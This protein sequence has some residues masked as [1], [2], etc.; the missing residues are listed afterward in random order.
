M[1]TN[2]FLYFERAINQE[3]CEYISGSEYARSQSLDQ[4]DIE[5]SIDDQVTWFKKDKVRFGYLIFY[6]KD[7][8]EVIKEATLAAFI[9]LWLSRLL[10]P[11]R[12]HV[13]RPE[14]FVMV[15]KMAQGNKI[16]LAPAV[17]GFVYQKLGEIC[18]TEEVPITANA[19]F[20][21]HLLV[22]WLGEHFLALYYH[23]SNLNNATFFQGGKQVKIK[24][25]RLTS[26]E[27]DEKNFKRTCRYKGL[28]PESSP[29]IEYTTF[30]TDLTDQ[31]A[32]PSIVNEPSTRGSDTQTKEVSLIDISKKMDTNLGTE[33]D[34]FSRDFIIGNFQA[35]VKLM[36]SSNLRELLK[37]Q[38]A[39]SKHLMRLNGV[40]LDGD[41]GQT[42]VDWFVE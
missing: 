22:G 6:P 20:P 14:T 31:T 1:D 34:K 11:T 35:I 33:V 13:V 4:I 37:S 12:G 32:G 41:V 29:E 30:F 36:T 39:V 16:S 28:S 40:V 23:R 2:S 19:A 3:R 8:N 27:S 10:F 15:C 17:L 25:R 42:A 18:T 26:N 38:E 21:F 7:E 9:A 24:A 5:V